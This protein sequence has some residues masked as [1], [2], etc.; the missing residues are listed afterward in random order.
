M[1]SES[2]KRWWLAHK[3]KFGFVYKY[4]HF[5]TTTQWQQDLRHIPLWYLIYKVILCL[6]MWS[7]YI[8]NM[9]TDSAR[10]LQFFFIYL[11]NQG[12]T[13]LVIYQALDLGLVIWQFVLNYKSGCSSSLE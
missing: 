1:N 11:T 10:S 12:L 7:N 9:A 3:P 8:A 5:F 2:V 4:P 6:F 13:I